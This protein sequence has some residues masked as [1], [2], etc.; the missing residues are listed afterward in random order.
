M[1]GSTRYKS[2]DPNLAFTDFGR[3]VSTIMESIVPASVRGKIINQ[4]IIRLVSVYG[5]IY[6]NSFMKI[7]FARTTR[8]IINTIVA[9][10]LRF[11]K[12]LYY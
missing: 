1:K 4:L 3:S 10:A 12:L 8:N 7:S 2:I 6:F 5:L 9:I 11:D